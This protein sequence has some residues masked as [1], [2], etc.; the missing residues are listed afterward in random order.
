MFIVFIPVYVFRF[1]S[2][3][4]VIVG[5]TKD[6]LRSAG[7]LHWGLMTMVFSISHV[8]YLL[9]LPAVSG[10]RAGGAGLLLYLVF[11]TQANDVALF[12]WGKSLGKNK[13]VPSVSP[14]KSWEGFLGGVAT[15]TVLAVLLSGLLTP[16]SIPRALLAGILIAAAGFVGDVTISAVKRSIGG[17]DSG[18]LLPGYGGIMD[19]IDSLTYTAPRFFHFIYYL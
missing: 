6:F 1:L 11:L 14:N 3:C 13:I 15:T 12:L 18:N 4:M 8:A 9:V 7:T 5:E 2:L 10:S 19:R 16:L 17:K